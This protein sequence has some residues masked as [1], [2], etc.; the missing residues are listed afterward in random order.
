[1]LTSGQHG[2]MAGI[3]VVSMA[4]HRACAAAASDA[5]STQQQRIMVLCSSSS[6]VAGGEGCTWHP[7]LR[8]PSSH[9]HLQSSRD[10]ES[11][12]HVTKNCLPSRHSVRIQLDEGASDEGA[13][14]AACSCAARATRFRHPPARPDSAIRLHDQIPPSA[15]H[16][17]HPTC[18]SPEFPNR[19]CARATPLP[20]PVASVRAAGPVRPLRDSPPALRP[21]RYRLRAR[22]PSLNQ[23]RAC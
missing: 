14:A 8:H 13:R 17:S 11:P 23:L 22:Q 12:R 4:C 9:H 15:C 20:A 10:Q 18:P 3:M 7:L 1:M 2:I 6:T 19:R 16:A 21:I 5:S